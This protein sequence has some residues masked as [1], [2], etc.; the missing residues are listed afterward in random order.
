MTQR[1]KSDIT[2]RGMSNLGWI[3]NFII[4]YL[5]LPYFIHLI[6]NAYLS[7]ISLSSADS[8]KN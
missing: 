2:N 5:Y 7:S 8:P 4:F 6:L 1:F 3:S